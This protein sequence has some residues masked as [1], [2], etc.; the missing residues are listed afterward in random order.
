MFLSLLL[1]LVSSSA[2]FDI[3][4]P[5]F[6]E[7]KLAQ[8][9]TDTSTNFFRKSPRLT[10]T[11]TT[12][13]SPRAKSSY[14]FEIEIPENAEASLAKIVINQQKNVEIIK[15]LPDETRAFNITN[16]EQEIPIATSLNVNQ[17]QNEI[18]INLQQPIPA[19]EK[20]RLKLRGINPLYGGV[21]QFGV[22]VFPEGDNVR[23]L[24]LGIA[25]LHFNQAGDGWF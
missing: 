24:Y 21:Y 15:L 4:P 25:R 16:G 3:L 18:T 1:I 8:T 11:A 12:Y 13:R 9:Q 23:S 14:I 22:T 19:G 5:V 10:R 2:Y 7:E 6:A 17:E 20:L